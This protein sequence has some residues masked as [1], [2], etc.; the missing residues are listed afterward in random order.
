MV[1]SHLILG[2]KD[3]CIIHVILSLVFSLHTFYSVSMA[4]GMQD[5]LHNTCSIASI[6]FLSPHILQLSGL[7]LSHILAIDLIEQWPFITRMQ[8]RKF[9]LLSSSISLAFATFSSVQI[10]LENL[11]SSVLVYSLFTDVSV[12]PMVEP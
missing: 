4:L 7:V 5:Q 2:G 1:F 11:Q 6:S 10:A 12:L 3:S 8:S 9:C